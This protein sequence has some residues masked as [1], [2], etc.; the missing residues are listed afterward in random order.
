MNRSRV[1]RIVAGLLAGGVLLAVGGCADMD[2]LHVLKARVTGEVLAVHVAPD[3]TI[4]G[5]NQGFDP[6]RPV[7]SLSNAAWVARDAGAT[8]IRVA[9]GQYEIAS[10]DSDDPDGPIEIHSDLAVV[11]GYSDDF[12]ERD[13]RRYESRI[14][15]RSW[16]CNAIEVKAW[17]HH[18]EVLA[19]VSIDGLFFDVVLDDATPETSW[20]DPVLIEL[21]DVSHARVEN[22]TIQI[23]TNGAF[24]DGLTAVWVG[25]PADW[26]NPTMVEQA[27]IRNNTILAVSENGEDMTGLSVGLLE[28]G[29]EHKVSGNRIMVQGNDAT[30]LY[31]DGAADLLVANNVISVRAI[32]GSGDDAKARGI[33]CDHEL[34]SGRIVHNTIVADSDET[35]K[36]CAIEVRS[37]HISTFYVSIE[38][39]I[40]AGSDASA[41]YGFYNGES[42]SDPDFSNNVCFGVQTDVYGPATISGND[43]DVNDIFFEVFG[44]EWDS[45]FSDGDQADYRPTG[46]AADTYVVDQCP[47]ADGVDTDIR[48]VSRPQGGA[49]DRG[50]YEMEE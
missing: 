23:R 42:D 41:S 27:I 18:G 50:A 22:C 24:N 11:G 36:D 32:T 19:D 39:N 35:D 9:E 30:G 47:Y 37:S 31:L 3:G 44:D 29:G 13:P 25:I 40:L 15:M 4:G 5:T 7:G 46:S 8:E 33:L 49:F 17:E 21:E 34:M 28:P 43:H 10:E 6:S 38:N 2:L 12:S 1:R 16:I 14:V 26:D 45:E 20:I 48:G